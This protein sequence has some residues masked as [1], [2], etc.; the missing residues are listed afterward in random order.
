VERTR[1]RASGTPRPSRRTAWGVSTL[2]NI[3]Q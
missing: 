2:S 3:C 1:R